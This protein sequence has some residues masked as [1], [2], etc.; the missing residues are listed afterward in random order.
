MQTLTKAYWDEANAKPS[1]GE[2]KSTAA[3]DKAQ[4]K[5]AKRQRKED[6]EDGVFEDVKEAVF[7]EGSDEQEELGTM[8]SLIAAKNLPFIAPKKA[9]ARPEN[10]SATEGESDDLPLAKP[11]TS[12]P[13][14]PL[15]PVADADSSSDDEI[16]KPKKIR[17]F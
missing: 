8:T 17:R 10:D 16:K 9:K 4:K 1:A 6:D 14:G 11:A 12:A 5:T 3:S 7:D 13:K 2:S 15:K